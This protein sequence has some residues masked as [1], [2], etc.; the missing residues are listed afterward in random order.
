VTTGAEPQSRAG[1]ASAAEKKVPAGEAELVRLSQP[2]PRILVATLDAPQSRN[3]LSRR[4]IAALD[5]IVAEAGRDEAI[6]AVVLAANGPAFSAGHDL[7]ELASHRPD[8]DG[9][10]AF[11]AE[12]MRACAGL[13]QAIVR[14]PK[15][16]IAAVEGIATAAGCQLVASCDLAVAG[17]SARFAT[18]GI[19]IGLFCSTPMVALARNV[20]R[21]RAMEMLLLGEAISAA[22]AADYGLVNRVT[23]EGGALAEAIAM[24]RLIAAKSPLTIAIGKEAFYRQLEQP[25]AEAYDY[26]AEVMVRNMMARDAEEG[27]RAFLEKRPP[28]WKGC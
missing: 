14:S 8:A 3:S 11:Y 16:V 23:K 25:L 6:A 22:E 10:R 28:L 17:A 19:N 27:I 26:A 24:A 12:T 20:S 2:A 5:G 13:M 4:M 1:A 21:K 7:K 18:P 9:G 15:P